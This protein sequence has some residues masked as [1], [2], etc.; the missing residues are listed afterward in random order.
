MA[1]MGDYLKISSNT[2][3][4]VKTGSGI[5]HRIIVCDPGSSWQIDI[6]DNTTG[7]GSDMGSLKPTSAYVFEFKLRFQNGLRITTSGTTAGNI[8]VVW[9]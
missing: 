9:E 4:Q 7:T 3:T 8:I 6:S 5:L 2:T 1:T